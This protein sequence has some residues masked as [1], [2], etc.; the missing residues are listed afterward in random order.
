MPHGVTGPGRPT[1]D[2]PS[3]PPCGTAAQLQALAE[4]FETGTTG[5]YYINSISYSS[6]ESG[7]LQANL[8]MTFY[9][10]LTE[11]ASP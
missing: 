8:E 7:L 5:V 2:L 6:E 3:P 11:A 4:Y 10:Y 9:Y 1:G